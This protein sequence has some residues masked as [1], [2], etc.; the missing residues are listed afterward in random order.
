MRSV[1]VTFGDKEKQ[2]RYD[3]NAM[4]DLEEKVGHNAAL[5]LFPD[6]TGFRSLRYLYWAGLKWRDRG[7]T[8]QRVGK[9]LEGKLDE[10]MTLNELYDP[11]LEALQSAGLLQSRGGSDDAT[12]D[13]DEE[14]DE[15]DG[16]EGKNP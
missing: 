2:L 14:A 8:L 6:N 12:E 10:G 13:A 11:V 5:L 15:D 16:L 9:L 4:A 3:F 7:I 1:Y